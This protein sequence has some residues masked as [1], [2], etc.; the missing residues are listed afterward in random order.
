MNNKKL[1]ELVLI[2]IP[3]TFFIAGTVNADEEVIIDSDEKAQEILTGHNWECEWGD[4]G[5]SGTSEIVY[6]QATLKKVVAK[7]KSSY[8]PNGWGEI[9]GKFKKG[10][11]IS[12][13]SN[14]PAPCGVTN[15]EKTTLYKAADG[16]YYSKG[17]YTNRF[18]TSGEFS[19]KAITK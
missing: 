17:T 19:C 13:L 2:L 4:S 1:Y 11:L 12:T 9:K 14:L 15:K 7:V 16:T 18:T 6:E 5:A 8:C 10:K 3:A